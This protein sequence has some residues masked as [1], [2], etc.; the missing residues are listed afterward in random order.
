MIGT[1]AYE[2]VRGHVE[3]ALAGQAVE[4]EAA[5][6]YPQLGVRV[7]HCCYRPEVDAA[8][9]V[10][11]VVAVLLDVTDRVHAEAARHERIE[12]RLHV[13]YATAQILAGAGSL[14]QASDGV[15][16]LVCG[17]LGWDVGELWTI[18]PVTQQI[19]CAAISHA[20]CAAY[21]EFARHSRGHI[22]DRGVG[23]PGRVWTDPRP[24]WIADLA[25]DANFPR[26]ALAAKAGL[27]A[28]LAFAIESGGQVFA[29]I[30]FLAMDGH[31]INGAR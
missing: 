26:A 20:P 16:E 7:M 28:A 5:I 8:G 15:L 30:D 19:R 25:S 11:G 29:V 17:A 4:F 2:V 3:A 23:L 22:F 14:Q 27:H 18:D 10:R 12:R 6:P 31:G 1:A 21:S 9:V 13:Q 24:T